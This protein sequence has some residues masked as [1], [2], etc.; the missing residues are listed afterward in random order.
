MSSVTGDAFMKHLLVAFALVAQGGFAAAQS[1]AAPA[2]ASVPAAGAHSATV[3]SANIM[4]VK[5]DASAD[6]HYAAQNNGE[7]SAVQPGNNAPLWRQVGA[8]VEGVSSLPKRDHPEAGVLI[9]PSVRYPGSNLA[10]A[11]EAWRQ[12]RNNWILPYGGALLLLVVSAIGLYHWRN[13][14]IR[15]RGQ[16]TG[17][18][19]ERFTAFERAA[20]GLN[21]MAFVALAVSGLVMAFGKFFILPVIGSTLFG[22]LTYALKNIHN[23]MG[24]VFAVSLLVVIATFVKDNIPRRED[25]TWLAKGGGLLGGHAVPSHRF[26]A[27]EKV[28]F[29]GG[30]FVLGFVVVASG[31][32]MDKL[33]PG[34]TYERST[35]Q[36]THMVHA[37]A[38]VLMMAMFAGHI[39]MGTLGMEGALDAMTTGQVDETWAQEHHALWLADIKAGHIPAQRTL[40]PADLP[41]VPAAPP[42]VAVAGPSA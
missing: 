6:P 29:W 15:L 41:A 1:A 4:D 9:Q 33:L 13:G 19:I 37:V 39:Y 42:V 14:T 8:G 18:T 20:H 11:G 12:V 32:V 5:A 34:L 23:F 28:L 17:T 30:V 35:L 2:A 21:A 27:G 16:P 24:P 31:L 38:A 36:V 40:E 3:Q 25:W 26:N 10:T 22:W 7:R